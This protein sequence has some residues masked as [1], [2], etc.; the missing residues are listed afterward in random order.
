MSTVAS[1][2]AVPEAGAASLWDFKEASTSRSLILLCISAVLGLG[3][4]GYGLFTAKGTKI[5][6]VPPEDVALVNGRPILRSDFVLQAESLNGVTLA[7]T[8]PEQRQKTLNDMIR[9]ELFVQRG[10]ELDFAASD[11]DVR[12]ALVTAVE[13]Q[14]QAD[15][16]AQRP[17]DAQL[18]AVYERDKDKYSSEGRMTLRSFVLPITPRRNAEQALA[19]AREAIDA[20]RKGDKGVSLDDVV[21]KHGLTDAKK[22]NGEEFYFSAR[23]HLGDALFNAARAL[24][25]GAVSEPVAVAD[26]VYILAMQLNVQPVPLNFDAARNRVLQ[27]YVKENQAK[28]LEVN[29]KYVR[30]QADILIAPELQK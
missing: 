22:T 13:R 23:I 16:T 7:Q 12:Q 10:V 19:Q 18:M 2:S 29:E 11:P 1:S 21:S 15:V 17:T 4:A 30:S 14:V 27:D 25:D 8:T 24:K 6:V 26:G 9:E 20:L 5:R 3:I 28:L